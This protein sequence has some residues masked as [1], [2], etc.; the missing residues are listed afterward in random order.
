VTRS[1]IDV[2]NDVEKDVVKP[3]LGEVIWRPWG[4][5]LGSHWRPWGAFGDSLGSLWRALGDHLGDLGLRGRKDLQKHT[6]GTSFESHF[7]KQ[8]KGKILIL[9][10]DSQ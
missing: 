4:E 3:G 6:K 8:P 5:H 2:E 7:G 10:R 9:D 1:K